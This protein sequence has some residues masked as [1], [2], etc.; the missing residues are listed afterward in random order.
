M[1]AAT[2]DG[3]V[4]NVHFIHSGTYS[5]AWRTPDTRP[6]DF[7]DIRHYIR[8]AKLAERGTFDAFFLA[9]VPALIDRPQYRPSYAL[10]PTIALTAIAGATEHIG[11][12]GT[13]STSYNDPYNVARRLAS[14][15][16]VSG[17]RVGWNI[18]TTSKNEAA[19]NF[20]LDEAADH[21]ARY[22]R[23]IEFTE[24]AIAL[25]ESWEDDA[26]VGDKATA[27]FVDLA[28]VHAIAHE[29]RHF[30]V[31]GPLNLP[32]SPQGR[33]V[34]VQ[35]GAS[36]DGIDLAARFADI[37]YSV[38]HT[39]EDAKAYAGQLDQRLVHHGRLPGSVAVCPGLVTILGSTEEE[40]RRRERE[41]WDLVPLAY[42]LGRIADQVGVHPEDLDLDAPLPEGLKLPVNGNQTFFNVA[43]ET[44][45]RGNL[46]VKELIRLQGGGT[47][48]P[49]AIG[50]PE[51]LADR[52][53]AWYLSGAVGGFNIM[54]DVLPSGLEDFVDH[55]VPLLR[56]KGIFRKAYG[57][58]TFRDRLG[59]QRPR[60]RYARAG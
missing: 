47:L 57:P 1:S 26:L 45:R 28:R 9:D 14:L 55:V 23:A 31:K 27:Q 22:E 42:G 52:M 20:G 7:Y 48:S 24:V 19:A 34:L 40:A 17:G 3:M 49:I 54:P 30:S 39:L 12:I 43:T 41:L 60:S 21:A 37:V 8:G 11:L 29:G 10:E 32:R 58:G 18:V 51:Q 35:A 16:H 33:P 50:T 5:S 25:W 53:E 56:R 59:L 44:A 36:R 38:S 13:L 46:T 4:L 2:R 15:D 6:A